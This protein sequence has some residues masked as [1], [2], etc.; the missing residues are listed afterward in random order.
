LGAAE[1]EQTRWTLT[2]EIY[3]PETVAALHNY[4]AHLK[5]AK[6]RTAERVRSLED[7][8]AEYGVGVQGG[9]GKE[10]TMREMAKVYR[11]MRRQVDDVQVDLERLQKG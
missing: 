5:D 3:T 9:E 10:K 2:K 8:L 1:A 7:E 4:G 6:S 11:E